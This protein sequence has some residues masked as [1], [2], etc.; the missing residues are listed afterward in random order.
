MR[1]G[2]KRHKYKNKKKIQKVIDT[3]MKV[4]QKKACF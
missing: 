3:K 4:I 2:K 1:K